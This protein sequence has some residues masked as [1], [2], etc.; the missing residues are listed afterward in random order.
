MHLEKKQDRAPRSDKGKKR[1]NYPKTR[2][3]LGP[4]PNA[5]APPKV[6]DPVRFGAYIERRHLDW[7]DKG[8]DRQGKLRKVLDEAMGIRG[9]KL[10]PFCGFCGSRL[11]DGECKAAYCTRGLSQP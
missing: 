9:F 4:R 7:L 5:G 6:D 1:P 8:G 10:P 3:P 11:V 2:K